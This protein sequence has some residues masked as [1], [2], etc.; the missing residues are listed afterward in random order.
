MLIH[1]DIKG[2]DLP[3]GTLCLTYDDGPENQPTSP[4]ADALN[5]MSHSAVPTLPALAPAQSLPS[6]ENQ[7]IPAQKLLSYG[8]QGSDTSFACA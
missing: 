3:S 1:G 4:V 5:R 8:D 7:W 6:T 2:N